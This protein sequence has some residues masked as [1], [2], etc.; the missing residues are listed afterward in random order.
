MA[1]FVLSFWWRRSSASASA[2][3][4]AVAAAAAAEQE[5]TEVWA[6]G[7]EKFRDDDTLD[8]LRLRVAAQ[9]GFTLAEASTCGLELWLCDGEGRLATLQPT[10][11]AE[12]LRWTC[13]TCPTALRKVQEN[14][15]PEAAIAFT[16]PPVSAADAARATSTNPGLFSN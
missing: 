13:A 14:G 3:A 6:M 5:E 8:N 9:R 11:Q 10:R 4:E 15:V 12:V 7:A 1:S 16:F 2:A